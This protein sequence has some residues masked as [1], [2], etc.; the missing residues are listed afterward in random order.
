MSAANSVRLQVRFGPRV[1]LC[2]VC[3][4]CANSRHHHP[5]AIVPKG[6]RGDIA[7]ILAWCCDATDNMRGHDVFSWFLRTQ[8]VQIRWKYINGQG[9]ARLA[10]I[11]ASNNDE[12]RAFG[13]G[14]I[15][16]WR[17]S[18]W[19]Q[20]SSDNFGEWWR[21]TSPSSGQASRTSRGSACRVC[22]RGA[23]RTA[24]RVLLRVRASHCS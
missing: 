24:K 4:H 22:R 6:A 1:C 7:Q 14:K 17:I 12:R 19:A 11:V 18:L 9:A 15:A 8:C 3:W 20:R 23:H 10:W 13:V 5:S 16:S 21:S 2:C